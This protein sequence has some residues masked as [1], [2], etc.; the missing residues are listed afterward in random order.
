[1]IAL[2]PENSIEAA[3]ASVPSADPRPGYPEPLLEDLYRRMLRIR[4]FEEEIQYHMSRGRI[5]GTTHLYVGEEAVAA[6]AAANLSDLDYITSTH[7]C[8]GHAIAKGSDLASLAAE[9]FGKRSGVCGGKGGSMHLADPAR[10]NLGGTGIVGGGIPIAVGAA[11]SIRRL[12]QDRAVVCFFGDGAMNEGTFH[13]SVNLAAVW[14]LPVLF[15][16]ENN[17]YGVSTHVRRSTN[18]Q[19]LSLRAA[20]Y[21]IPGRNVDGMDVLE[22]YRAVGEALSHVKKK[23]PLLLVAQTYRF[24]G[25]SRSDS[26]VYRT[27]EEI[28]VWKKKDPILRF[29]RLLIARGDLS[30]GRISEIDEEV[31]DEVDSAFRYAQ[32]C[33]EPGLEDLLRDVYA[34]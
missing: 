5:H 26:N 32:A 19:D 34:D 33:E 2:Q 15:L 24:L 27:Q 23:G 10:G 11:L 13:E 25:H 1:M 20:A 28:D 4:L 21:G 22:V 14:K 30:G 7:R 6:G 29:R 9:M 12:G 18:V 16:C 3:S 8:H 17:L 31:R